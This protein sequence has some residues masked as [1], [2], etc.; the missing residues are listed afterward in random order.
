MKGESE[1]GHQSL[2]TE[3][4]CRLADDN[5]GRFALVGVQHFRAFWIYS[6]IVRLGLEISVAPGHREGCDGGTP[7]FGAWLGGECFMG[8]AAVGCPQGD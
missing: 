3:R 5:N 8:I 4:R 7:F 6:L 2:D 1:A